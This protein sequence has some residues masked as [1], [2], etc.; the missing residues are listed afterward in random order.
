M[1]GIEKI[2]AKNIISRR[3]ALKMSQKRLAEKAKISPI[4]LNR[5]EKLKQ[6]PQKLNLI[7]IAEALGCSVESL[8]TSSQITKFGEQKPT[9]ASLLEA[10]KHMQAELDLVNE[11]KNSHLYQ[12]WKAADEEQREA[13]D[14]FAPAFVG[15][16]DLRKNGA[17]QLLSG[18]PLSEAG[19]SAV[20]ESRQSKPEQSPP[21]KGKL[22]R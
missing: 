3:K 19:A 9:V 14:R 1:E 4:T 5:I 15:A 8:Y 18:I 16:D 7:A 22:S 6:A 13:L 20:R 21:R 10:M 11:F 2:L 17:L 12:I